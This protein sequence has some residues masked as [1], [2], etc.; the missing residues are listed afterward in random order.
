MSRT[1]QLFTLAGSKIL[2]ASPKRIALSGIKMF[3]NCLCFVSYHL[4]VIWE[5]SG[6]S[7]FLGSQVL[8]SILD[9]FLYR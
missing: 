8:D 1:S 7:G 3:R 6:P 2:N 9:I 5:L 4:I